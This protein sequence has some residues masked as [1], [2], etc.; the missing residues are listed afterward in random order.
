V[1][2]RH[3]ADVYELRAGRGARQPETGRGVRG[4]TTLGLLLASFLEAPIVRILGTF[5]PSSL[6]HL[7]AERTSRPQAGG[8]GTAGGGRGAV[9]AA[10]H[11]AHALRG[12]S[13]DEGHGITTDSRLPSI[14]ISIF[15]MQSRA[16][17][18]VMTVR[19]SSRPGAGHGA[20]ELWV[21]RLL[22]RLR[23][24]PG[25]VSRRGWLG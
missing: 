24:L 20:A 16:G 9:R 21:L 22:H 18:V 19:P 23:R 3:H 5:R 14:A 4:F 2:Q 12:Q 6:L 7:L 10:D 17:R 15:P 11:T 1:F 25:R 13:V 8:W